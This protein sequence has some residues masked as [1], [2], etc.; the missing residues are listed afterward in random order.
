MRRLELWNPAE[1]DSCLVAAKVFR[2]LMI[3]AKSATNFLA[4]EKFER[5]WKPCLRMCKWA[6]QRNPDHQTI[7]GRLVA[8][9]IDCLDCFLKNV[10]PDK[11][12]EQMLEQVRKIKK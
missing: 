4:G 10:G 5:M 1:D 2:V 8:A 9:L 6:I 3:A 12:A 11:D 7:H